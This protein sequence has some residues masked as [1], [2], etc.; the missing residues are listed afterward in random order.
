[1]AATGWLRRRARVVG[2]AVAAGLLVGLAATAG[3]SAT[4]STH[5]AR[6][7]VFS[8]GA[9][10]FGFGTL[11]W[12]SSIMFGTGIENAQRHLDTGTDWNEADSRRAMARIGSFGA[13]V[14]V[15]VPLLAVALRHVAGF[16]AGLIAAVS[17]IVAGFGPVVV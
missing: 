11:G 5:A 17:T 4:R 12:S 9:L 6:S 2:T 7:T 16:G 1:M 10:V 13:G 8:L 14:M 3:L 15:A